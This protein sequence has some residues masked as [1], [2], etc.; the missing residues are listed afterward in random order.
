MARPDHQPGHPWGLH[1]L[2][3]QQQRLELAN[4]SGYVPGTS[5]QLTED[6]DVGKKRHRLAM[7]RRDELEEGTFE[8]LLD[9]L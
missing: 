7:S 3:V 6:E 5:M 4:V 9:E 2:P 1:F 8:D